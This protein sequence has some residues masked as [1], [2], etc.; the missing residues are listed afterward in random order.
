M[1]DECWGK[2]LDVT[3]LVGA[4]VH[5][6]VI[7]SSRGRGK[8]KV[9]CLENEMRV[10]YM[11]LIFILPRKYGIYTPSMEAEMISFNQVYTPGGGCI[12]GFYTP[13]MELEMISFNQVYTP[14]GFRMPDNPPPP[15]NI[16]KP[17][18]SHNSLPYLLARPIF[19]TNP[20]ARKGQDRWV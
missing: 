17:N 14:G 2:V 9:I 16:T 4:S 7:S 20:K 19:K 11:K 8:K 3:Q 18:F 1:S 15:G 10:L 6:V 12:Y 5:E 13:S